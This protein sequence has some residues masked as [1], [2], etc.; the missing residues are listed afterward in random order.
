MIIFLSTS[1]D[2]CFVFPKESSRDKFLVLIMYVLVEKKMTKIKIVPLILWPRLSILFWTTRFFCFHL[3]YDHIEETVNAIFRLLIFV[4]SMCLLL[5][6][7]SVQTL[8]T[9]TL[10]WPNEKIHV[11]RVT[12]TY[13][14]FTGET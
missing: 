11:F 13:L 12:G 2:L 1:L 4:V 14:N 8:R 5:L 10:A 9:F 7:A 6:E 3:I